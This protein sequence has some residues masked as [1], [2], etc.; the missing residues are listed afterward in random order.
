MVERELDAMIERRSRQKDSDEEHELWQESVKRYNARRREENRLAR[1]DYFSRLAGFL[2]RGRRSMTRGWRFWRTGGRA[3]A[4]VRCAAITRAKER[5]KA[6]ATHGSYCWN[7]APETAEARKQRARKAGRAG[8]NGRSSGLS[9]TAKAKRW[10]RDLVTKAITGDVDRGVATAAFMG[11]NVL[12]RYIELEKK[13][14]EQEEILERLEA[15][16]QTQEG[17]RVWGA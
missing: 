1:C 10:I 16:E 14:R 11:F 12:A 7:H 3:V 6:E 9:E 8:G 15:L 5:C 13:I 2:R 17:G 4:N